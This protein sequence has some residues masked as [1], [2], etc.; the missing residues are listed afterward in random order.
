MNSFKLNI[1]LL[2]FGAGILFSSCEKKWDDHNEIKDKIL[3]ENLMEQINKDPNLSKFSEYL[4]KT[5]Y[6]KV[7]ASTRTF[8]VW[9]PTNQA[10]QTL[11]PEVINTD[12]KLVLFVGNH[13]ASESFLTKAPKDSFLRIKTLNG[14]NVTFTSTSVDG[15]SLAAKD[16]YVGNGILH[17]IST[18]ITPK[19]SAWQYLMASSTLQKTE[20]QS[21]TYNLFD[22]TLAE[23]V[24]IDPSTGKPIYK[25]GT[26]VIQVNRFLRRSDISNEDSL[27]TYIVLTDQ[28][29]QAERAKLTKYYTL[30]RQDSTDSL[31]NFNVIK[32]LAFKG[33]LN[34]DNFPATAYSD[35]DSVKFHLNK[36]AIVE[37]H[38]V[39]N[40]IVYVMNSINYDLTGANNT[41]DPYTKLKPILIQAESANNSTD[42]LSV[43]TNTRPVRRSPDGK[44]YTQ[45]QVENHGT[46]SY[47]ARYRI[48][49]ANSIKYKVVWRVARETN[50][51]PVSPAS[52]VVAG[53]DLVYFPL[54]VAFKAPALTTGLNYIP[55]PGVVPVLNADGTQALDAAGKLRFAPDYQEREVGEYTVD[56]YYST[57]LASGTAGAL[58]LYLVGSTTTG[59]GTNTLLMDYVKLI[60]VP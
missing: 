13:I 28:A 59:N 53:S 22:P 10:L 9:A 44:I 19:V 56:K 25:E 42:F 54:R 2:L 16:M 12:E 39:S 37:T 1:L 23:E 15:S 40:G 20:L 49:V 32:D 48:P 11:D 41:Y 17:T 18:A 5:G 30:G 36:S 38:P 60:P 43:K 8:T 46:A 14:K 27:F 26:G 24:G 21:L 7:V 6:D 33:I 50:L 35:R 34:A 51:V 29:F 55:K 47:W 58:T 3:A 45:L 4:V 52:P 57:T 31:T